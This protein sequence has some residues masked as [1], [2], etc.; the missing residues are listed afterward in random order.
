VTRWFAVV[1]AASGCADDGGPR[2]DEVMPASA[3]HNTTVMLYGRRFCGSN[4]NC[5]TAAGQVQIG[6]AAQPV[7][8]NV[9]DYSD[10]SAAIVIPDVTPTGAT[11]IVMTVN[12]RASN[13]LDFEVLP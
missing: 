7:R 6:L 8:A 13:A 9:T 2:L 11:Q 12:E 10:T 4:G 3:P 1:I 5:A